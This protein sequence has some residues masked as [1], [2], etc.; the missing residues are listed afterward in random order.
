[1]GRRALSSAGHP[2]QWRPAIRVLQDE[3]NRLFNTDDETEIEAGLSLRVVVP[4]LVV[5]TP[6]VPPARI[7]TSSPK[8]AA[9]LRERL[10][11]WNRLH[12]A[13][14]DSIAAPFGLLAPELIDPG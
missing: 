4:G 6:R 9:N 3:F 7:Q 12:F 14:P 13:A 1:M 5:R 2:H 11:T 10:S 8:R